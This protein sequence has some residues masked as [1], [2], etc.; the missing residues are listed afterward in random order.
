MG[1]MDLHATNEITKKIAERGHNY[2]LLM[3]S[4]TTVPV[5]YRPPIIGKVMVRH[6]HP[7]IYLNREVLERH[8]IL[9][10]L[11]S[12]C[13]S[14]LSAVCSQKSHLNLALKS[15]SIAATK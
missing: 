6:P 15:L 4:L 8:C 13:F 2:S 9:Q 7:W 1:L 10:S 11:L 3:K 12:S 14:H 5:P